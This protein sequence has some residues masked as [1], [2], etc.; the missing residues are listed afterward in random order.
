MA[1]TGLST[2]GTSWPEATSLSYVAL[3]VCVCVCIWVC[4]FVYDWLTD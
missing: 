2:A 1:G 4:V 3:C